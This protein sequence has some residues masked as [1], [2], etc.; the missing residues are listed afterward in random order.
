[1]VDELVVAEQREVERCGR[2]Y[3]D[4]RQGVGV[5]GRIVILADDGLATGMTMRAAVSALG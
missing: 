2:R 5:R 3:R 1:M 4:G